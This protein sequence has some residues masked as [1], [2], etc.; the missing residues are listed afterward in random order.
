MTSQAPRTASGA[1]SPRFGPLPRTLNLVFRSSGAV[2]GAEDTPLTGGLWIWHRDEDKHQP[3]RTV[4]DVTALWGRLRAVVQ[5]QVCPEGTC[6][7][8]SRDA[9]R[10]LS[11]AR[12][13]H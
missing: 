8:V 1:R 13:S 12:S 2:P 3:L 10:M 4:D 6:T 5:F 9:L 7:R 11:T